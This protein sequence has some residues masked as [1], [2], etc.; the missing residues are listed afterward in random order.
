MQTLVVLVILALA[1]VYL[2]FRFRRSLS[3]G[4]CGCGC[5]SCTKKGG[6]SAHGVSLEGR[7]VRGGGGPS[8]GRPD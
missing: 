1:G 2:F 3:G 8:C 7:A 4:G 6:C 5:S